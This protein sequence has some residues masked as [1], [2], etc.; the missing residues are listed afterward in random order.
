MPEGGE[1][2]SPLWFERTT[3][4]VGFHPVTWQGRSTIFLYFLLVAT[5]IFIYSQL[6]LTVFVIGF[7]TIVFTLVVAVKSDLMKGWPPG[8]G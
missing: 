8:R 1:P 5:A 6:I 3:R 7:Y 2:Q 4:G